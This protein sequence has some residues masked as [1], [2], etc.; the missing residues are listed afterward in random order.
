M[1][2]SKLTTL[3]IALTGV[4]FCSVLLLGGSSKTTLK[5][6]PCRPEERGNDIC[7]EIYS[8]VCGYKPGI[9]CITTPCNHVTYPNSCFACSDPIVRSF[10]MGECKER[11]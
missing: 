7:I 3:A 9:Q 10:T 4:I 1:A 6:Y 8:P 5:E 11:D 2:F